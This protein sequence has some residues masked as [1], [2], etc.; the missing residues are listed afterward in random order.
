MPLEVPK[1]VLGKNLKLSSY[2]NHK[3]KFFKS[4]VIK[5]ILIALFFSNQKPFR[6]TTIPSEDFEDV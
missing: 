6:A 1:G 3:N 5:C 4:F 2:G